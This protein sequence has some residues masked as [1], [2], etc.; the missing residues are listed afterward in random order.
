MEY[1]KVISWDPIDIKNVS[2][3]YEHN[4]YDF[5]GAEPFSNRPSA[6]IEPSNQ[7]LEYMNKRGNEFI[8]LFVS[9]TGGIYDSGWKNCEL[10][11]R[12]DINGDPYYFAVISA[13]WT[14]YPRS[15]GRIGFVNK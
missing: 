6:R 11:K 4:A 8:P 1:V 2:N 3:K 15:M 9:G 13:V 7:L 12:D 10:F 5:S 14:G